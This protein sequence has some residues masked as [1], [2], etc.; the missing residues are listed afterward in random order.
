MNRF[1]RLSG[2][3]AGL[4]GLFWFINIS[5]LPTG[6]PPGHAGADG[7][8]DCS[9]CH[10]GELADTAPALEL[11]GL[12]A[13]MKAGS[14]QVFEL[15]LSHPDM[16]VA[17][18]QATVRAM[19]KNPGAAGRLQARGLKSIQIDENVYISHTNPINAESG[20]VKITMEWDVPKDFSG[21]ATINAAMVAGNDD[22][23]AFGDSALSLE[24]QVIIISD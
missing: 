17:G 22:E 21:N 16:R 24:R 13:T 19:D 4:G 5:A 14:H 3:L 1:I 15:V 9:S 2:L 12:T 11:S 7:E 20:Q 8:N 10:F 23:S 6:A 18:I